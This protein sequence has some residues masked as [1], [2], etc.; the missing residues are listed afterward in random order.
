MLKI[1]HQD[2]SEPSVCSW[3]LHLH[4]P[5][6]DLHL[7]LQSVLQPP[8]REDCDAQQPLHLS[9]GQQPLLGAVALRGSGSVP[10][11]LNITRV[12]L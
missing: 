4:P 11:I 3:S 5:A 12:R 10:G 7:H 6:A 8:L 1:I 9:P 2:D